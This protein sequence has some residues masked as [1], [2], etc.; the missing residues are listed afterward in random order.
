MI[1]RPWLVFV[2]PAIFILVVGAACSAGGNASTAEPAATSES[3]PTAES[4][5]S[6][7]K[8]ALPTKGAAP[9]GEAPFEMDSTVYEHPSGAFSFNPPVGWAPSEGTSGVVLTSPDEKAM[10]DFS[11]TNTGA[12]LDMDSFKTFVQATE[13]NYFSGRTDYEQVD[14]QFFDD[15]RAL[16]KKS[17][18]VNDIPQYVFTLYY[19]NG[20]AVY[21]FDFWS[22]MDVAESYTQPY[23]DLLG[24]INYDSSKAA[25][26]PVYNFVYTFTDKDNLFQFDVPLSWT[27]AY[28]EGENNYTDTFSSPDGHGV[29]QNISYD[30][31]TTMTKSDAGRIALAILNELYTDG[32]GDIKITGDEVQAD[33]SERLDWTSRSGGF[34]GQSFFETRGTTFLMLSQL[35]D[36]GFEDA[37]GTVFENTLSTYAVP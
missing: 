36:S 34:S 2:I 1:K 4:A 20:P 27:Y 23:T 14:S 16:V 19:L 3:L 35:V 7:P 18:Q 11:V 22:D 9:S 26:L 37:Y 28:D 5:T 25:E 6:V 29:M 12:E 21:S 8:P 32:A 24:T 10:L 31:G 30:D 33:G 13:D 17:F 15:G